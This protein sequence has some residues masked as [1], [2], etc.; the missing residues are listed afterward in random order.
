MN[1]PGVTV[2][3]SN[4]R[5]VLLLEVAS[6]E[7][8]AT[9]RSPSGTPDGSVAGSAPAVTGG[10]ACS[11][12]FCQN[13]AACSTPGFVLCV[14]VASAAVNDPPSMTPDTASVSNAPTCTNLRTE[15]STWDRPCRRE[16]DTADADSCHVRPWRVSRPRS[17]AGED[18]PV[19]RSPLAD[20]PREVGVLVVVAFFVALGFGIVAPAL[21][22][23]ARDFGV[24]KAAAASVISAF[25]FLRIVFAFPTGRLIDSVGERLVLAT[26]IGIVAVS[27][28]LAGLSQSYWQLLV[29]RGAGGVG[30]AMFSISAMSVLVRLVPTVQRA[31]AVGLWSGGFLLGGIAA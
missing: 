20:L 6:L 28:F 27:S 10:L 8:C 19:P 12:A 15:P 16:F 2:P 1:D 24:G 30:S 25:A 17:P 21:P 29:L 13:H 9:A 14:P 5:T 18:G 31:R 26:G 4:A 3:M 7:V 22:V 23:F 11:K